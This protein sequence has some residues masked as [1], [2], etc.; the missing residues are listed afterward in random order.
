MVAPL[1]PPKERNYTIT[2]FVKNVLAWHIFLG[3]LMISLLLVLRGSQY[4]GEMV[5]CCAGQHGIY[6][7]RNS[8]IGDQ[9]IFL[10]YLAK[11]TENIGNGIR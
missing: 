1:A 8:D 9:H 10:T 4:L 6:H 3:T 2:P 7:G 11:L 5:A